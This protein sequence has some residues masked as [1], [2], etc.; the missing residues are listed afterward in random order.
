MKKLFLYVCLSL[1][2]F[3]CNNE[4]TELEQTQSTDDPVV[5]M[6]KYNAAVLANKE[7]L[8][9]WASEVE[10][11]LSDCPESRAVEIQECQ[12][13]IALKAELLPVAEEF[14]EDLGI[15]ISDIEEATGETISTREDLEDA[16]LGILLFA[17]MQDVCLVD[18]EPISRGKSFVDCFVE[19]TG[20]AAGAVAIT[21]MVKGTMTKTAI[22]AT[23]KVVAR[24]GC[25]TLNGIGLG[26]L[27]AEIAW[28]MW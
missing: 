4:L 25:R 27:A 9:H 5:A 6:D 16:I 8:K 13:Y 1:S 15:S 23:L 26:L 3:A 18:V 21:S 28:C 17:S 11:L 14:T 22:K 20:I 12:S 7:T 2:L 24:V 19:A 10:D